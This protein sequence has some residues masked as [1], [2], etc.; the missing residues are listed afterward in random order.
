GSVQS[1]YIGALKKFP[2]RNLFTPEHGFFHGG[3]PV[4]RIV[5]GIVLELFHARTEPL[6]GVV[7][8]VGDARAEDIQER[9]TLVLDA[10][11]DQLGEMLLFTTEATSDERGSGGQS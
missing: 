7:V 10:L 9:E 6:I 5:S 3:D 1:G 11:L 8:V 2:D 4:R